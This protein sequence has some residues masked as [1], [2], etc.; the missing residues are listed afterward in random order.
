[1]PEKAED[2]AAIETEAWPERRVFQVILEKFGLMPITSDS[3]FGEYIQWAYDVTDHK[4]I[5]D[6]YRFYKGYLAQVQPHIEM[7][8]KERIVPIIEGILTDSGYVE[9]AVNIPNQGLIANL[10]D[11][12]VVEVPATVDK[13]GV[14]GIAMGQLPKGFAGLLM[15]Q[16]A[17]HDLTAEAVLQKSKAAALQALLVDPIVN[18]YMGID[19]LLDTMIAYQERW[20]GYLH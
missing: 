10:P 4:G 13:N 8:I 5:L 15:N 16:V 11:W 9:E 3:H 18:N 19:E 6:F 2:F 14:H 20:L 7:R 12:I 1:M 17:V